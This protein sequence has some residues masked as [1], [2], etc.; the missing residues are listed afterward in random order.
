[1]VVVELCI[2]DRCCSWGG[3]GCW[4][5]G[6]GDRDGVTR[7]TLFPYETVWHL[8]FLSGLFSLML[9]GRKWHTSPCHAWKLLLVYLIC[10]VIYFAVHCLNG[11]RPQ[12]KIDYCHNSVLNQ[13]NHLIKL[14]YKQKYSKITDIASFA[15]SAAKFKTIPI[16]NV[17]R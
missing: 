4:L 3:Q 16:N 17:P 10:T 1:M 2:P 15:R 5:A 13:K 6:S 11:S 9:F 8:D 14:A 12:L 7:W